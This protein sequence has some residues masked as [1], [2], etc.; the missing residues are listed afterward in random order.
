MELRENWAR[1]S[2]TV[3]FL[4]R[5]K[6]EINSNK[7][8][9]NSHNLN[10]VVGHPTNSVTPL[11]TDPAITVDGRNPAPVEVGSLSFYL[12]GFFYT[13]QVVG[14]GISSTNNS[15]NSKH[16]ETCAMDKKRSTTSAKGRDR[17]RSVSK[18][19]LKASLASK[20][21]GFHVGRKATLQKPHGFNGKL[22]L[23]FG[24][25]PPNFG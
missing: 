21:A 2:L 19:R 4:S 9:H 12:Q 5:T 25:R 22:E 8:N 13:F 10:N 18:A 7:N 11:Q 23:F 15:M 17:P 3:A 14:L 6:C 16:Q 1:T 20:E 24:F